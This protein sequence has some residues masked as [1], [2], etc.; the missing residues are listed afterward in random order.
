MRL[1]RE[2]GLEQSGEATV[3]TAMSPLAFGSREATPFTERTAGCISYYPELLP[4]SRRRSPR[5]FIHIIYYT[6]NSILKTLQIAVTHLEMHC[7]SCAHI[8]VPHEMRSING[9]SVCANTFTVT[10]SDSANLRLC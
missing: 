7:Q 2:Q 8:T 6:Q 4:F 9:K 5:V 10:L 3:Q 1:L